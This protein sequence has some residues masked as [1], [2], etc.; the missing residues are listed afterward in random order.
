MEGP[1][2]FVNLP[3]KMWNETNYMSSCLSSLT[4]ESVY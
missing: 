3:L 1:T 2:H 4:E